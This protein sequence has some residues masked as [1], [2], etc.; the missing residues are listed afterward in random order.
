[1]ARSENEPAVQQAI[2][3]FSLQ[4]EN[5]LLSNSTAPPATVKPLLLATIDYMD[6]LEQ[7]EPVAALPM[8]HSGSKSSDFAEWLNRPDMQP[9]PDFDDIYVKLL[10]HTPEATTAIVWIKEMAPD[11]VHANEYERFLIVEGTCTI[12][13]DGVDNALQ[14][15]DY[16]EIPLYK[17]HQVNVTSAV[18]CKVV[19]QRVAA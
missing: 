19:L 15:G 11:E 5:A 12:N 4:L 13:I 14:A 6:R 16:L 18:P 3:S 2:D 10:G 8:L 1:M 17:N 9:V 7:G